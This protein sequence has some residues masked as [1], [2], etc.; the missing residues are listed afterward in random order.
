MDRVEN[1]RISGRVVVQQITLHAKNMG[2]APTATTAR[3]S[4][5]DTDAST[6][7]NGRSGENGV[8]D[9]RHILR[10]GSGDHYTPL[11]LSFTGAFEDQIAKFGDQ[12]LYTWLRA[13]C[14]EEGSL[15]FKEMRA[16]TVALCVALRR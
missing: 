9:F 7:S 6:P 4:H 12:R 1:R 5:A 10:H 3:A 13:D 16:A 2:L 14:S 15:S 11:C 8:E